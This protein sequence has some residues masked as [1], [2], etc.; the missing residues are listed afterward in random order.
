MSK[1]VLLTSFTTWKPHHTSNSSDD[2]LE[3]IIDSSP[4]SFHFLRRLP[5]DFKLAPQQVL[6][7]FNELKPDILV[8]CGMGEKRR[9]LHIESR[10]VVD[11]ETVKTQVDLKKLT[12]GL[13]MTQISHNAG[14]FV[15]NQ[16]YF[17]MLKYLHQQTRQYH[18]IFAHVPI[19]S[20]HN[21]ASIIDNFR[22]L[23]SRLAS[24]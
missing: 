11:N 10:A 2:L 3:K 23:V 9:K 19:L 1:Q 7:K 22:L 6:A 12:A 24:F 17:T 20:T 4:P 15:C 5:V 18:C 14:R 21:T 16:L 8:C 13:A